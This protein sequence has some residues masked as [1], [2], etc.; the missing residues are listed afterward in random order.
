M[1]FKKVTL[2]NFMSVGDPQEVSLDKQGLVG[3]IAP[4][5]SGKSTIIESI[6][7]CLW[8][9]TVRDLKADEVINNRT[10]E[11][12]EVTLEIEDGERVWKI[13]RYRNKP[14]V[15][16]KNDVLVELDGVDATQGVIADTQALID[17]IVGITFDTFAQSVLL[18]ANTKSFCT[19][20]DSEQKEVLE[21]ILNIDLLR[22]AQAAAKKEIT[23]IQTALAGHMGKL[24]PIDRQIAEIEEDLT[25]LNTKSETFERER[26]IRAA[27]IEASIK[28][29]KKSIKEA[30]KAQDSVDAL[31][32]ERDELQGEA[33]E[34]HQEMA[35]VKKKIQAVEEKV[36]LNQHKIS[37][38]KIE[39]DT[40]IRLTKASLT[41]ISQT[42]GTICEACGQEIN[43]DMAEEQIEELEDV[44]TEAENAVVH[45]VMLEGRLIEAGDREKA[46]LTD[47]LGP[48]RDRLKEINDRAEDLEDDIRE[49]TSKAGSLPAF[50]QRLKDLKARVETERDAENPYTELIAGGKEDIKAKKKEAKLLKAKVK[51][52][53]LDLKGLRFWEQGFGNK[54]LKSYIMDNVVPF[55]NEKAQKYADIMSDGALSINFATQTKLKGGGL[56]EKF[57]VSVTNANGADIYKGNSSG[58]RRRSD[59]AIGWALAD[60]AATRASKPIRFRGLDEPFENL[61]DEGIDAVFKLL[62]HAAKEYETIF[63]ITHNAGLKNRF[64]KELQVSKKAG[65][66]KIKQ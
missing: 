1:R 30:K 2:Q 24:D 61:D 9:Q 10:K 14:D 63:C 34:C 29:T 27:Q 54:G 12:C 15:R 28:E 6:V 7:W 3:V 21:D 65:F 13:T 31:I 20:K 55:L 42:A 5:G 39:H 60:L 36:R 4:N 25:T 46:P 44:V 50:Q 51:A 11:D 22:K 19:L 62:Q 41:K 32:E 66:S 58:E 16:K 57:N 45:L 17:D 23:E 40:I 56:R 38:K 52:A 33:Y 48:L 18:T 26:D 37:K 43:I 53:E 47:E 35:E 8:G 64:T 59:V 49:F